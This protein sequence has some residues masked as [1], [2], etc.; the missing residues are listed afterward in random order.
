MKKWKEDVRLIIRSLKLIHKVSAGILGVMLLQAAFASVSP[1]ITMYMSS[2]IINGI[3]AKIELRQ[4][5]FLTAATITATLLVHLLGSL[6]L[7]E[8]NYLW[9]RFWAKCDMVLSG[10]MMEMD[11][12]DVESA[13][14][15]I[16][17]AH[18]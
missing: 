7:H 15:Q 14:I 16:G 4:L 12:V 18:V 9:S 2:V 13:R 10:K 1:F 5:L 3:E 8:V 11:Y 6:F 17:R